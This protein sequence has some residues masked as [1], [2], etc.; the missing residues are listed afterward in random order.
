MDGIVI[1]S[2]DK[3]FV[4]KWFI[5]KVYYWFKDNIMK[6]LVVLYCLNL[7]IKILFCMWEILEM[8]DE[9]LYW[10]N[11]KIIGDKKY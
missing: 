6:N 8:K 2:W 7:E 10:V 9:I 5:F 1:N 4:S 3:E 11:L